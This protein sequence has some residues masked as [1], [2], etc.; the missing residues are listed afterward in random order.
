MIE[1]VGIIGAGA[2]GTA[3]ALA[4]ARAGRQVILCSHSADHV[5][6]LNRNH[7]NA[8]NLPGIMFDAPI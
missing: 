1:R 8:R 6:H 3:L 2:W 4:A 7:E 5:E